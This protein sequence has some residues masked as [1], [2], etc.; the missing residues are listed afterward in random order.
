[1]TAQPIVVGVDGSPESAAA[2]SAGWMLAQ[3][4]D[5]PCRLVHAIDDVNI[6]LAMA[7]TG[8]VT[9]G[10]QRA[11]LARAREQLGASLQ[12]RVP[13]SVVDT[14]V[15]SP[16]SAADV[17][18]A[19]VAETNATMLVLGGKHHS[20]LGRWLGGS[21]VQQVVR[22]LTVPLLVTAGE[23]RAHPRVMVAVDPSYAA[24]PTVRQAVA[25][26]KLL[27]S[28]LHALHVIDPPPAIAELPRDWS[29]EIVERDI[30]PIIPI[31][32][33]AKVFREG[34]PFSTIVSEAAAWR[35][36]VV[37]VGSHGK[38]WVDRML[39]GSVT[40]DLLNNLPCAVLVVPVP[41]PERVE[42]VEVDTFAAA[43]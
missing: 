36:D 39:I 21:T 9:E 14:M 4:A 11:A 33:Q 25:F 29:R 1:M 8:M 19:V 35:A 38:G 26:A 18:E 20:R 13:P 42:P 43:G 28:P 30:W 22:R 7:G 12:H 15:V 37:V 17:L 41:K 24:V 2:A 10:L 40:E 34:V 3:A 27:G 6:S 31:V 32:E 16:A 5:G 23:M